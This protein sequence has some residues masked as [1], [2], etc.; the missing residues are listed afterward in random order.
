MT[1]CNF[2]TKNLYGYVI[3]SMD[4]HLPFKE[5]FF[6]KRLILN[7]IPLTNRHLLILDAWIPCHLKGN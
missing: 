2:A 6:P 4:D 3:K 7:G 5:I 1:T